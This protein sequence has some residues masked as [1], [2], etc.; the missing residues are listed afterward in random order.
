MLTSETDGSRHKWQ[1]ILLTAGFGFAAG[2]ALLL[3]SSTPAVAALDAA[4]VSAGS[5]GVAALFLSWRLRLSNARARSA[6]ETISTGVCM[7]DPQERLVVV[8]RK[9]I[10]MYALSEA[11][12][13]PGITFRQVLAHR[14]AT[15]Q[16]TH[17]ID[18]YRNH[19]L[20]AIRQGRMTTAEVRS[21]DG[22]LVLVRNRPMPEGGWVG[23]H[24]DITD[25]RQA[26]TERDAMQK[27]GERR[28]TIDSAIANFRGRVEQ[29]LRV[30]ADSTE[31]MRTTATG[32]LSSCGQT[33][34]RA[35]SALTASNEASVNVE[36]AAAAAE[37]LNGSIIG[38]GQQ[39]GRATEVVGKAVAETRNTNEQISSLAQAAQKIGDVIKLIR[40]IAGQTNLLALNATIEAARAGEAGKGFAVVASEVKTLAVQT[41]RATEEIAVQIADLQGAASQSV[42]AIGRISTRMREIDQAASAVE[43]SVQQ[44]ASA[45]GEISR[46][47]VGAAEGA[48]QVVAELAGVA[49]AATQTR[50]AAEDVLNSAQTVE[51][52][53]GD[54]RREVESFLLK[55]AV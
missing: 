36:G 32:L 40:S 6:L 55:V 45:T 2:F 1:P 38:I 24:E 37:E 34:E 46:N 42:E 39:I 28:A 26:E 9:Y 16:F 53:G 3:A 33:Q 52:C 17:D 10:K 47:V 54:L 18:D 19:L 23:T 11:V 48:K 49:Q 15:G 13:K 4:I 27:F 22:R 5:A 35:E 51:I 20:S 25:R 21:A 50:H 7:F 12:V 31:A 44:Q 29:H 14:R 30:V 41:A 8:N 43:G